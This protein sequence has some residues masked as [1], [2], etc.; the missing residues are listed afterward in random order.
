VRSL[1]D[2][3]IR[4]KIVFIS[5]LS[6]GAALL[7]ASASF[8]VYELGAYQT[9]TR[10]KLA[11]VAGV[12]AANSSAALTFG[13]PGSAEATLSALRA[14]AM[15]VT[16][17]IYGV[18]EKLFAAYYRKG[19][20]GGCHAHQAD[21]LQRDPKGNAVSFVL[22]IVE[23]GEEIGNIVI[24]SEPIDLY[25]LLTHYVG[26]M[27]LV[28]LASALASLPLAHWLQRFI[29]GPILRLVETSK[30]VSTEKDFSVRAVSDGEDEV[31]A[32][33]NSF[34]EMLEQIEA[35]DAALARHRENLEEDVE[36][37]T[38]EIQSVNVELKR[39]IDQREKAEDRIRYLAYYDGLTGL[40]NRQ[41][42]QERLQNALA[43]AKQKGTSLGLLFLDLD[44]FK[45]VNDTLGH[46]VGDELLC[47]VSDRMM[48]CVRFSDYVARTGVT[49]PVG[50][51]SRLGGDEFTLLLPAIRDPQDAA[52][53]A[54]RVLE[55]LAKP[56]AVKGYELAATASIGIAVY[57]FDGEDSE[58]LLRNADTAMYHAKS[59]NRNNFQFY[60]E[61]MNTVAAR[62]LLIAS[63]LRGALER[64]E[65]SLHY[66]PLRD[67][68]SGKVS[69][70]EALLRWNDPES[71]PV[72]PD[73]FIPIAEDTGLI[74]DIG[75]W[76][77]RT[78]C[79]Q[80]R[81]W[82]DEGFQDI[83]MA[84]NVSSHQFR[85]TGWSETVAE[86]LREAGLSPA[87]LELEMTETAI[88]QNDDATMAALSEL[89]DMGVGLALDDFGTGYSSLSY[90]RR[91]PIDRVKIDRSFVGDITS[92]PEDAA[93]TAAILAMAQSLQL[94]VVAEGVETVEQADFL[95]ERGCDELQGYLFSRPVPAA[96][97]VRFL[98]R[99]KQ[100]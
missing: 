23:Q 48:S 42:F 16:A 49:E 66:Q 92:D 68:V 67:A 21:T 63:R 47:E 20:D 99:R 36:R 89:S 3:P 22:P 11:S 90:L 61:E 45:Q 37:R 27:G 77:L 97:F 38:A 18:D 72:G 29:S 57:P 81:A 94:L 73:E 14:E 58:T 55:D 35:R 46:S 15:I 82:H 26:I 98:E 39:Q 2:T 10:A 76:V 80:A 34:N 40:P 17:C 86:I 69:G 44:R 28:M 60:T 100:K 12:I 33:V 83:R 62:K 41:L 25:T 5:L 1:R 70:A 19:T 64:G 31:G 54:E 74:I 4:R 84:V 56:F 8:V 96:D 24:L 9:A 87:Q 95:R 79:E 85:Q 50:E 13:D 91:F 53:V 71:G 6:S 30:R 75:E 51:V 52:K 88:M 78:A 93:I 32:L 59:H 7:L 65:F 43:T